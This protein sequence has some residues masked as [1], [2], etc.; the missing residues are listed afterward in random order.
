MRHS[1]YFSATIMSFLGP[2][3]LDI[4]LG[5]QPLLSLGFLY[6]QVPAKTLTRHKQA[7]SNL[8]S[9]TEVGSISGVYPLQPPAPSRITQSRLLRSLA[10]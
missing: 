9:V 5:S 3:H 1:K 7:A 4:F 2:S 6:S 8:H 10:S